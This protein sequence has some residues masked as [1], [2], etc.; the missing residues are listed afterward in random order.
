MVLLIIIS[1]LLFLTLI[2]IVDSPI[3]KVR[4][5]WGSDY[6]WPSSCTHLEIMFQNSTHRQIG[7]VETCNL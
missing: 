7:L 6:M 1:V 3:E 4:N 2:P 5:N